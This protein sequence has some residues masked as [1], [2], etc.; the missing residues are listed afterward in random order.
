MDRLGLKV[1][2]AR[3][4]SLLQYGMLPL[5]VLVVGIAMYYKVDCDY[6]FT[7][8]VVREPYACEVKYR[9]SIWLSD[10]Y[11]SF[12]D[13]R[14]CLMHDVLGGEDYTLNDRKHQKRLLQHIVKGEQR[15]N[16]IRLLDEDGKEH[17]LDFLALTLDGRCIECGKIH[18]GGVCPAREI[19]YYSD[20]TN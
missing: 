5:V 15:K 20:S 18:L 1:M 9:D 12:G 2:K 11:V 14:F 4:I 7:D 19:M 17:I 13:G 6:L 10:L 8:F 3:P 16:I